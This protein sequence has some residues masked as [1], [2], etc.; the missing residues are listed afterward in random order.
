MT[1]QKAARGRVPYKSVEDVDREI[2]RLQKQVESGTMKIVD[3][4]KALN[5]VSSLNRTKKNFTGF[6]ETE[7]QI[8][9]LKQQISDLKKGLDNPEQKALSERYTAIT[10]E[11]DEMKS[12]QDDVYKNLNALRDERSKLQD[13]QKKTWAAIREVKDKYF[14]AR[15]AFR[16]WES[17]NRRQRAIKMREEREAANKEKRRAIAREKLDEAGQPAFMDEIL[18]AEGLIRHF[19]PSTP[20]EAKT[21]REPS[22]FGAQAQRT[23]DASDIKGT[24]LKKKGDEEEAYFIGG[25]G[26]KGKKGR[27]TNADAA[28][29]SSE[30]KFNLNMGIIEELGKVGVDPPST[31]ADVPGV[32]EKLKAKV[33]R[34]KGD[35][36]KKTK[37][38]SSRNMWVH[39]HYR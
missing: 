10:K 12:G 1:E 29:A 16:D 22:K 6:E 28:P 19:D 39:V 11:L 23:V 8:Q 34:W 36:D 15:N 37:E 35:Q 27:K 25:G 2:D 33:A 21:L 31:Q 20:T 24:A 14:G 3:E 5:E 4:K 7:K 9:S 32:V 26:K 18:S 38:V 30:G 13:E 17:D